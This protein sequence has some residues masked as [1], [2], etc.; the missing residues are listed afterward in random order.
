MISSLYKKKAWQSVFSEDKENVKARKISHVK[1]WQ[2][3]KIDLSYLLKRLSLFI[4]TFFQS[5]STMVEVVWLIWLS[6]P[7]DDSTAF[8]SFLMSRRSLAARPLHDLCR[9][10]ARRKPVSVA[11]STERPWIEA[12][13][14]RRNLRSKSLHCNLFKMHTW[15]FYRQQTHWY[16]AD[17]YIF[18]FFGVN[19]TE[20]TETDL[21]A[22]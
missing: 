10:V 4:D 15:I 17:F 20:T 11:A 7:T 5:L 12:C 18:C 8:F 1:R 21:I 13:Q 2:D 16:L 19:K 6:R 14:W 22:F 9:R 3:R